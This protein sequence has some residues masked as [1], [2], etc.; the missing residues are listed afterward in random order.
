MESGT[1]ITVIVLLLICIIPFILVNR[2]KKKKRNKL[3]DELK[4]MAEHYS[5]KIDDFEIANHYMIGI[6]KTEKLL[7]FKRM[8]TKESQ[9][10]DLKNIKSC[11][12]NQDIRAVNG[13]RIVDKLEL[14]L[15]SKDKSST[16][17]E[18]VFYDVNKDGQITDELQDLENWSVKIKDQL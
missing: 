6:D 4:D 14:K 18:L 7:F 12:P 1:I 5:A 9:M 16:I 15:V 10:I 17:K 3:Y 2:K 11:A 13:S 8:T